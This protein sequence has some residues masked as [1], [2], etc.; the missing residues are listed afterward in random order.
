MIFPEVLSR[1]TSALDQA[2]IPYMLSGSFASAYY[3]SL[4]S[5][6]DIDLV[7][8]VTPSQLQT[9]IESLPVTEYYADLNAALEAQKRQ[10]LFNVIDL[11]TG[12]KIDLIIRKG[13]VFIRLNSIAANG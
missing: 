4:R 11:K 2:E 9:F 3:G 10:S 13:R 12:W 8:A 7:I 6:Q 1:I 5:T